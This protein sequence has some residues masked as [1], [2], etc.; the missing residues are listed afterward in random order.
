MD[1]YIFELLIY[2]EKETVFYDKY[3]KALESVISKYIPIHTDNFD[4]TKNRLTDHFW[5]T[6]GGPWNYNQVVGAIKIFCCGDQIRGDLW[7]SNKK[8]YTRIM[9]NKNISLFGKAFEMT[10]FNDMTNEDIN[11]QLINEI[12]N[13]IKPNK[14]LTIDTECFRNCSKYIDWKSLV[15][16]K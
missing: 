1:Y 7:L 11:M 3:N 9:G 10:I 13:S 16:N 5:K 12:N 14:R 15:N 6:Y 4:N 8:R 2:R